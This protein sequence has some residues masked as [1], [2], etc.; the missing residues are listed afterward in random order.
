[1]ANYTGTYYSDLGLVQELARLEVY[2]RINGTRVV[3]TSEFDTDYLPEV[4]RSVTNEIINPRFRG[5]LF[6]YGRIRFAKLYF[7]STDYLHVDLPFLPNTSEYNQFFIA[8]GFNEKVT[9][10]G[11]AGELISDSLMIEKLC[12]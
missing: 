8:T 11:L 5:C 4:Y 12:P 3:T 10:V 7:N 9:T 2:S 1:M 6:N